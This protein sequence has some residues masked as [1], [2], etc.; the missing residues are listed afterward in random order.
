V[1]G[2]VKTVKEIDDDKGFG[3]QQDDSTVDVPPEQVKTIKDET[4][5]NDGSW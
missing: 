3:T 5:V 2:G 1:L 4:L